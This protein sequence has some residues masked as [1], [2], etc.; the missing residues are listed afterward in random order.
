MNALLQR[1][2]LAESMT[3]PEWAAKSFVRVIQPG[4]FT[5]RANAIIFGAIATLVADGG[6]VDPIT[7]AATLD[8]RDQLPEVGGVEYLR[9]LVARP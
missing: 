3:G 8:D 2:I 9:A 4:D 5:D 6:V 1:R 7:V